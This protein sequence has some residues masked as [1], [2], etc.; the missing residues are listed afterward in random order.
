VPLLLASS[1]LVFVMVSATGDPAPVQAAE[2][3]PRFS[4]AQ[5]EALR[6]QFNLDEPVLERY[7]HWV[8]GAVRLDLG[9]D[10]AGHPVWPQIRSGLAVTLRLVV[11]ALVL[12]VLVAVVVGVVSA[13]RQHSVFD[14]VTTVVSLVCFSLPVFWLAVLLKLYGGIRLNEALGTRFFSTVGYESPD[15]PSGLLARLGDYAGHT[16]LPALCLILVSSAQYSRFVR[17][18]MLEVLGSDYLRTARAKGV[19]PSRVVLD[20]GLRNAL[21]PLTTV[22]T[23]DLG[24]LLGGVVITETVFQWRGMGVLFVEGLRELDVYKVSGWLLVSAVA[25]IVC[26]LIADVLY[27]VLD[28]RIRL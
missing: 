13:L 3:N 19:R 6:A 14:H 10:N 15:L 5:R 22:V 4:D 2:I 20:H 18:S 24:A 27:A 23:L 16:I 26:N 17:S 9:E 21:L 8:T 28:P 1:L 25:I 11:I 7:W 12:S